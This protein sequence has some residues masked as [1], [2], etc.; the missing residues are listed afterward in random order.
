MKRKLLY[1]ATF[2][3]GMLFTACSSDDL[4]LEDNALA[5]HFDQEGNAWVKIGINL[6]T[7]NA[8]YNAP[9]KRAI[10]EKGEDYG[11][12][13][14]GEKYE[15]AVE[16]AILVLFSGDSDKED[17]LKLVSAY[18][19]GAGKWDSN[20]TDQITTDREFVQQI[21][22][23]GAS[24]KLY[25]YVILNKHSFF[26]VDN[27][28]L[29]FTNGIDAT[30]KVL[31]NMTFG[32]FHKLELREAGRRYD[33]NSFMMTNMPY[34]SKPGGA[35]NPAGA[36]VKNLYPVAL[37]NIYPSKTEA[38]LGSSATTINVERVLAKVETKWVYT[39]K[40][41]EVKPAD[42]E[43]GTVAVVADGEHFYTEDGNAYPI[44]ILGWFIDNTNPNTYVAR[45]C[46][47]SV[48]DPLG[49][50][51]Y[52]SSSNTYRMV[53]GA[54]VTAG[55]YRTFW[56][57]DANYDATADNLVTKAGQSLGDPT[58]MK[59]DANGE[60]VSGSLRTNGSYYYCPENTFDVA[61]QTEHN[62]TRVVVA[63]DF[64][65]PFYCFA[66]ESGVKYSETEVIN[67]T[68]ARIAERVNFMQWVDDYCNDK[69]TDATS[70][71]GVTITNPQ[72]ADH[73]DIAGRATITIDENPI[74][75][76]EDMIKSTANLTDAITAYKRAVNGDAQMTGH[77][78]YLANNYHVDYYKD[79]IA[80]YHALIKHFGDIETPWDLKAHAGANNDVN[81]VYDNIDSHAYLGRYGVVRNNWYKL[82]IEGIRKIGT[83]VIPELPGG[84]KDNPDDQ[85]ENFLKVKIN[86]TPWAIRK[87][88]TKL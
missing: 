72:D 59:Y 57:V 84:D 18:Q 17:E 45:N 50:L 78:T 67:Y 24:T 56:A 9:K 5:S 47:E 31:N 27:R 40:D 83:A 29:K 65:E 36:I 25:A 77:N 41:K 4:N 55:A 11:Q 54:A 10:G 61:H 15:Y 12:F 16:N 8:K 66:Q 13:N 20:G 44:Q 34:A 14:D 26:E 69:V 71:I 53:N 30:D 79:G 60:L 58:P 6:P 22:N 70:F 21:S 74:D 86:I 33:A 42:V 82:E 62:T 68:K 3:A 35:E 75:L 51:G 85:V 87:Q 1:V 81:G 49:Y 52:K 43:N 48:S 7:T 76:K 32:E 28:Q 37:E 64:G 46:E 39:E 2:A 38:E 63:A 23:S 80:Y 88:S 19:L 73:H